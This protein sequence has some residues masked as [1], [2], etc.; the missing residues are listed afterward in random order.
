MYGKQNIPQQRKRPAGYC[1]TVRFPD[2]DVNV[3]AEV[4]PPTTPLTQHLSIK[5]PFPDYLHRLRRPHRRS[6][7]F[8]VHAEQIVVVSR[9]DWSTKRTERSTNVGPTPAA[10]R[11]CRWARRRS[12]RCGGTLR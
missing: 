3:G 10:R 5:H 1:D 8:P 7:W 12:R 9:E 11:A 6:L 4:H 2:A